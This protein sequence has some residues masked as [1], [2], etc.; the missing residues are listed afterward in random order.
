MVLAHRQLHLHVT[1]A[2]CMAGV[3][4]AFVYHFLNIQ[5]LI[6]SPNLTLIENLPGGHLVPISSLLNLIWAAPCIETCLQY[7]FA[8]TP[9]QAT[10]L[11]SSPHLS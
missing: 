6:L 10:L 4:S 11:T 3:S 9:A 5:L 1:F 7:T 2:V 8:N